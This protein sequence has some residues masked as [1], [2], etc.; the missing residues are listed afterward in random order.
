MENSSIS[1]NSKAKK[2]IVAL[3]FIIK[4]FKL[5]R[6]DI[7]SES[8]DMKFCNVKGDTKVQGGDNNLKKKIIKILEQRKHKDEIIIPPTEY[9]D[10]NLNIVVEAKSY[11]EILPRLHNEMSITNMHSNHEERNNNLE[12]LKKQ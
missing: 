10:E 12:K 9:Y 11:R 7:N 8:S 3:K 2:N 4:T 1:A 5:T 6:F